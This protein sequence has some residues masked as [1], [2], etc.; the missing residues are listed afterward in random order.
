MDSALESEVSLF[1][2]VISAMELVA[3]CRDQTEV[4]KAQVLIAGFDL[5]HL[6]PIESAE[7]YA[8]LLAY[9]KSHGLSIPDALIAAT[10]VANGLELAT[11]N[12]RH[13]AMIPQLTVK[14]PY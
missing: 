10:A 4:A 2:S 12:E 11:D 8:L 3:G 7:A 13:F 1:I 5:L 6:S 9:G 14:R